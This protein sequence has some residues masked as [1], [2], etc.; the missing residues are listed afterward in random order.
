MLK[1]LEAK[2]QS[3]VYR[4]FVIMSLFW[5][6]YLL[7]ISKYLNYNDNQEP[8]DFFKTLLERF[9]NG[10]VPCEIAE[11]TPRRMFVDKD[12]R[13]LTTD[14]GRARFIGTASVN[15]RAASRVCRTRQIER[16]KHSTVK[17]A[18]SDDTRSKP[19][20]RIASGLRRRLKAGWKSQILSI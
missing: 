9:V 1:R 5:Y 10:N 15:R 19:G 3:K 20:I 4:I 2:I 16:S 14:V 18:E 17:A 6:S 8:D 7:K 13:R 12:C 11:L